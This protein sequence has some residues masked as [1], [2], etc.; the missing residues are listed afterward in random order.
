LV[1]RHLREGAG[2]GLRWVSGRSSSYAFNLQTQ[3][4][5]ESA[6]AIALSL[7]GPLR[8]ETVES[9]PNVLLKVAFTGT[10]TDV[11]GGSLQGINQSETSTR[12]LAEFRAPF[13][14]EL[15]PD[16][17]LVGV[18][19]P[20]GSMAF[21]TQVWQSVAASLQFKG[22]RRAPE[23]ELE[24]TDSIGTYQAHYR[25]AAVDRFERTKRR[26]VKTHV[27]GLSYAPPSSTTLFELGSDGSLRSL[28]FDETTRVASRPP[29]PA[30]SSRTTIKMS[31]IEGGTASDVVAARSAAHSMTLL[32]VGTSPPIADGEVERQEAAGRTFPDVIAN[33]RDRSRKVSQK[34]TLSHEEKETANRSYIALT[35]LIHLHPESLPEL[36]QMIRAKDESAV[37]LIAALR[38][39]GSGQA[40]ATLRDLAVDG[41]LE[42]VHR[43]LVMQALSHVEAPAP[44]TLALLER[45]QTDP[46]V[47]VQ[48]TYGVG[49]NIHRLEQTNPALAEEATRVLTT[50]LA[51]SRDDRERAIVLT[52]LGNAGRGEAIAAIEPLTSS[53]QPAV[54]V[55]AAQSLRR[56]PGDRADSLLASLAKDGDGDVRFSAIDAI[57]ERGASAALIEAVAGMALSDSVFRARLRAI[58]TAIR[59]VSTH[60][61]LRS[62]LETVASND[63]S[64]DLRRIARQGLDSSGKSL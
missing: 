19:T 48:A 52:A 10:L 18:R 11:Q 63:E 25:T 54:R 44:E 35:G 58:E 38:D 9:A 61:E 59:W 36:A 21:V 57:S 47:G 27:P 24:E 42:R 20:P 40:Q 37:D 30:L 39:S 50:R 45:L 56:I 4:S 28:T 32:P 31:L 26:Y 13:F 2:P 29:L 46:Q 43:G 14:I 8:I 15:A 41:A 55:A 12:L 34:K 49:S 64:A 16:G 1:L 62:T 3:V 5:M 6:T 60:Q 51:S 22:G 53:P 23:W 7:E 17:G 33:L